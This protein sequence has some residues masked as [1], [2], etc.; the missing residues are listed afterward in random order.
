MHER[1]VHVGM[2]SRRHPWRRPHPVRG[3]AWRAAHPRPT[4]VQR[5]E[6]MRRHR[7][8]GYTVQPRWET[9]EK[10]TETAFAWLHWFTE[11]ER[12]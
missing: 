6:V 8:G 1:R 11:G 9:R 10:T 4:S 3:E 2:H 7:R 12:A 5:E